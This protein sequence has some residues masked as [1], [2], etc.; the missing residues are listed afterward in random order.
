MHKSVRTLALVAVLSL[1]AAPSM[2]AER[3]GGNPRPQAVSTTTVSALQVVQ[4]T[5]LAYFGA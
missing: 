5:V 3:M 4:Y 2:K 1:V